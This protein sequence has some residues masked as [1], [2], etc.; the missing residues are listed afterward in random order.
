MRYSWAACTLKIP[1]KGEGKEKLCQIADHVFANVFAN[2]FKPTETMSG[3]HSRDYD[4]LFGH[5][6]LQVHTYI[7]GLGQH[8]PICE[9]HDAHC[10]RTNDEQNALTLLNAVRARDDSGIGYVPPMEIRR[11][12]ELPIRTIE[13][14]YLGQKKTANNESSIFGDRYNYVVSGKYTIGSTTSDYITNTHLVYYP[15][16]QDKLVSMNFAVSNMSQYLPTPSVTVV[17]D[18][19]DNPYGHIYQPNIDKP[20]HLASHPGCVQHK[21]VLLNTN[22]INPTEQLDGFNQTVF[23]SLATNIILP[24]HNVTESLRNGQAIKLSTK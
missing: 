24:L 10:E 21:N 8:S 18:W 17:P 23:D 13:S 5:G 15:H 3:P 16:P 9:Y 4:F 20:S 1:G 7:N 19:M 11:L 14:K 2:Y 22:A 6:A 12:A